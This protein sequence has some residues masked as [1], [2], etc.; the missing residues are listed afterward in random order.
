MR[1]DDIQIRDPFVL[2]APEDGRFWLFGSTDADIWSGPATGFDTYWS[3]DLEEWHGPLPAFRPEPGFWSHTQYW[4]PEVHVHDGAFFMFATFT[5]EG[6][7]RGTQVLRAER[8]EGPYAPWSPGPVT[9]H[10]WEC[11]DGTLHVE[12]GPDGVVP[13]LVFC[14]EWKDVGDGEVHAVRLSDDLREAI[15]EPFLLFRASEAAWARPLPRPGFPEVHVTDG[16]WMHRTRDGRLTM[17]W[18]SFGDSGYA[19]GV[20]TSGSGDVRGP[21]TQSDTPL[22]PADGGHGMIFAD[23]AGRLLLTLHAPNGTPDERARLFP[24]EE[25]PDGLRLTA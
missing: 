20:A 5:A 8:P 6:R 11:L 22:W 12:D 2:R 21:W 23:G 9:P 7:R 17:L 24:L 10:D 4:A 19:M 16:P 13:Y 15:G 3:T 1:L 14:R 25:T 18:S